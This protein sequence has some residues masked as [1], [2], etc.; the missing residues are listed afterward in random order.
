MERCYEYLGCGMRKCIMYET[1]DNTPCWE[2]EG[3]L[4]SSHGV[5]LVQ[6]RTGGEKYVCVECLYYKAV[7]KLKL[8][9]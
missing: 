2:V 1:Q 9:K 6:S 8:I 4:C 7:N 3:T 5:A